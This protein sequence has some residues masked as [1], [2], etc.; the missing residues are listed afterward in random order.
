MGTSI[1]KINDN[2]LCNNRRSIVAV[3]VILCLNLSMITP[4]LEI[5]FGMNS[6]EQ[7]GE[8]EIEEVE[9]EFELLDKEY[10]YIEHFQ[11]RTNNLSFNLNQEIREHHSEVFTPPPEQL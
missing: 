3:L 4:Y 6:I 1:Q 2:T 10:E 11:V 8:S 7:Y 5:N 9:E